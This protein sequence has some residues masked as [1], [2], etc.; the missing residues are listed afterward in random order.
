MAQKFSYYC[1]LVYEG[2]F[3]TSKYWVYLRITIHIQE[4]LSEAQGDKYLGVY[5]VQLSLIGK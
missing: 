5:T 2:I 4:V 3:L 1:R